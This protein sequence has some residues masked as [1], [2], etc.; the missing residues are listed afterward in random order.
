MKYIKNPDSKCTCSNPKHHAQWVL[1]EK[2]ILKSVEA[3]LKSGDSS[4]LTKD[5]YN[6]L[7]NMSGFIAH[8]DI[9]GFI[10]HY[11]N[12]ED[13]RMDI[14]NSSDINDTRFVTDPYFSKGEQAGY[15]AQ[16]Y[17]IGIALG[18]L[19]PKY[20]N[21]SKSLEAESIDDKLALLAEIVKRASTDKVFAKDILTKLEIL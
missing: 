20:E 7:Y 11:K 6:F 16:K 21:S 10:A 17:R 18:E 13:L 2:G 14:L 9:N 5:A 4:Q 3:V 15:Y 12:T 1:N 19:A 8:Y